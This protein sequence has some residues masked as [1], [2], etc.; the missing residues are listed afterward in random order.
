MKFR[1][2]LFEVLTNDEVSSVH[3]NFH[4]IETTHQKSVWL[5][6]LA[7]GQVSHIH[8]KN[9][10]VPTRPG[11]KI[12]L[13]FFNG[14][15]IAFKRNEQI[16]V[17]DPVDMKALHNSVKAFIW[18]LFL[19]LC[20]SIPWIGYLLGIA[21]GG[22]A[23]LTGYPLV[24]RYRHFLGN[25]LFALFVLLMSIVVWFPVQYARGDYSALVAVYVKMAM[26]LAA[27]FVFFQVYKTRI[28]KRYLKRA[29][30]EL[31]AVWKN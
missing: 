5:K 7:N 3:G 30:S 6:D 4:E 19:A 28:E 27:G 18:A 23:L 13:A 10:A 1:S 2:G 17:E 9:S 29:I 25:R 12:A 22:F 26:V 15:I 14:E 31:N 16:P 24:G 20:C 8:L 11:A 21:M